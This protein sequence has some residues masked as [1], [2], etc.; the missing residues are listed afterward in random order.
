MNTLPRLLAFLVLLVVS[1]LA[2]PQP[3]VLFIVADDLRPELASYGSPAQ[4][5]NLDRLA[6]ARAAV[7]PR[8][9]PAGGVQPVAVVV[10]H[11]PA[12]RHAA[13]VEQ[14]HH[15]RELNPDVTT[16]P[17]WFKEHGYDDAL[18]RQ[19]LPQLAHEGE[20]RSALVERAGVPALREPRRRRAAGEGRAAA[21]PRQDGDRTRLRRRMAFANAATCRTRRTTT[22]ASP[23]RRCACSAR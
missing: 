6:Q 13:P 7:R 2:A 3:N 16:L 20:G 14:R 19:D 21:E 8:L 12:A 1:A 15:F 18:R 9:L 23:P 10:P 11:R 5:P 22:A 4:T 17:L